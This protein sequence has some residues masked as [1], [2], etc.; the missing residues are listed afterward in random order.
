MVMR[1]TN[2]STR[3][4]YASHPQVEG[5]L[6]GITKKIQQADKNRKRDPGRGKPKVSE[7]ESGLQ[8][9]RL[10]GLKT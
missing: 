4:V 9:R 10:G 7:L 3:H 8:G 1:C 2:S 6:D 5:L